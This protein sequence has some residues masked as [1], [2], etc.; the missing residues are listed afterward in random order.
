MTISEIVEALRAGTLTQQ[1]GEEAI[2]AEVDAAVS[3]ACNRDGMAMSA[4]QGMLAGRIDTNLDTLV[5]QSYAV[6]DK[7]TTRRVR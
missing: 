6:A 1:Q 7:M 2:Q 4:L 3:A 5:D